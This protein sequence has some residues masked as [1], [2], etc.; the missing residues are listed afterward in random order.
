MGG[1]RY[2]LNGRII[3]TW[4]SLHCVDDDGNVDTI[5]DV[6]YPYFKEDSACL[7]GLRSVEKYLSDPYKLPKAQRTRELPIYRVVEL[8]SLLS[9]TK[10]AMKIFVKRVFTIFRQMRRFCA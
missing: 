6:D 5:G 4:Q 9:G 3:E 10:M 8:G 2:C 7:M 1:R